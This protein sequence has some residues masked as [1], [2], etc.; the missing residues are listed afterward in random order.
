MAQK[1]NGMDLNLQRHWSKKKDVI[2]FENDLIAI[3]QNTR[4]RKTKNRFQKNL[5]KDIQLTESSD[6]MV[7]FADKTT[8]LYRL[9]KVEYDPMINKAIT[10]NNKKDS[11]N[12]KKQINM[13]GKR[14]L[15]SK[16]VL[17][18]LKINGEN[19]IF[20]KWTIIQP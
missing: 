20:K 13:D 2:P 10:S 4:F 7:T 17:N 11:C 1:Q 14:I 18:R 3:V 8:K 6:K 12:I 19:K 9:T 15:K 5:Q 16:E